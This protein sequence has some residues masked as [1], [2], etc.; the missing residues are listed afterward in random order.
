MLA[1]LLSL[2]GGVGITQNFLQYAILSDSSYFCEDG[3]NNS[4]INGKHYASLFV[5]YVDRSILKS[6]YNLLTSSLPSKQKPI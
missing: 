1:A 6:N 4:P 3:F 5:K 2:C